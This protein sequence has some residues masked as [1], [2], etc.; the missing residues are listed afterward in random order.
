[1]PQK[2]TPAERNRRGFNLDNTENIM[3]AWLCNET[4]LSRSAL[5]GLLVRD[6]YKRRSGPSIASD[7]PTTK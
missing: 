4:G 2:A 3:I 1:M 5:V 6:E 7:T